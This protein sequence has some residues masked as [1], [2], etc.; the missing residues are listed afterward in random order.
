MHG[1]EAI[2]YVGK[3]TPDDHRH[4]VVDVGAL[5]LDLQLDRLDP[6]AGALEGSFSH[7]L[8]LSFR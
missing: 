8:T 4:G 2:A 7:W 5:H 3:S 6:A 1:L